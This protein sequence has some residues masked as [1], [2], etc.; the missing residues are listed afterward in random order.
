MSLNGW[1]LLTRLGEAQVLLPA[2]LAALLWLA[3]SQ[4]ATPM[5]VGWLAGTAV[6]AMLTTASKVAFFGFAVGYA[7]LDFTGISGHAMFAAVV[8]PVLATV[9]VGSAA[10]RWRALAAGSGYAVAALIA[11]SRLE[12]G[13]HSASEA[14]SGLVIGSLASAWVLRGWHRPVA[15]PPLWLALGLLLWMTSLP[16]SA[17]PSLTHDWV[18]RLSLAVSDRTVPYS[19]WRMHR[20]HRLHQLRKALDTAGWTPPSAARAQ[21]RVN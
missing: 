4:R 9:C 21:G 6:V 16:L 10:P 18:V 5:A 8:L 2:M 11:Y 3:W 7:P 19:R 1:L 13:A 20:D 15:R 17:P 14:L 12:V